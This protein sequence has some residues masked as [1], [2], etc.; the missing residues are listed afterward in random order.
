MM[1]K[2][3]SL[4]SGVEIRKREQI[5]SLMSDWRSEIAGKDRNEYFGEED[6]LSYFSSDGFFPGYY[7]QKIKTLFI[8]REPR[9]MEGD[10]IE[11]MIKY[12]RENNDLGKTFTRN[13]LYIIQGIK[14]NGE[15]EFEEVKVKTAAGIAKEM[16]RTKNYGFAFVNISKYANCRDDG[17][18]ADFCS[19]NKFLEHSNLENRNFFR[20]ELEILDPDIII[21]GNLWETSIDHKYLYSCF[22][23]IEWRKINDDIDGKVNVS[24]IIIN[25]KSVK[26]LNTYHFSSRYSS[27]E[28]FYD[29]IM[30][31]I[32]E[33]KDIL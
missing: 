18:N 15:L 27:K 9:Y 11:W 13:L 22:G 28:Y 25:G 5:N 33:K 31:I 17:G 24:S 23:K 7:N 8:G 2:I 30:E 20:E 14:S 4:F 29:P 21:T 26:L 32:F 19:I 1:D 16:V 12:Y 6:P 10:Y 3:N